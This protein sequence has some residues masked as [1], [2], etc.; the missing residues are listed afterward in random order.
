MSYR[1][2]YQL[3]WEKDFY[4]AYGNV[5]HLPQG[6]VLWRGYELNKPAILSRPSYFGSEQTAKGYAQLPNR[7]L[8]AFETTQDLRLLDMRFMKVLLKQLFEE[9]K[10]V[11]ISD[12]DNRCIM[13]TTI[14]FGLCSLQHQIQLI[15]KACNGSTNILKGYKELEKS[16]RP[17]DTIEQP[18]VRVAETYI[19]GITMAFIKGLLEGV[20]DGFISPRLKTPY[21]FEK[22]GTMSPEIILFDPERARIRQVSSVPPNLPTKTISEIL[23]LSYAITSISDNKMESIFYMTGGSKQL[24]Y[25][26]PIEEF[27]SLLSANDKRAMKEYNLA[28]K[29]GKRWKYDKKNMIL[30]YF[31]PNPTIHNSIF[32]ASP[33]E[34]ETFFQQFK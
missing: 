33:D 12:N 2:S 28:I 27:N 18:G 15:K 5:I 8:G 9:N 31:P 1:N 21:H 20:A 24:P 17:F 26:P 23:I 7:K 34:I 22:N 16:L 30:T 14:S 11:H 19:D 32:T 25:Y 6:C 4:I 10:T 13:A 29:L 3:D